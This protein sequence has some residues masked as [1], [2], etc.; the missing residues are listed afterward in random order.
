MLCWPWH[1]HPAQKPWVSHQLQALPQLLGLDAAPETVCSSAFWSQL[2][3][4]SCLL[5]CAISG[6]E[7]GV[8]GMSLGQLGMPCLPQSFCWFPLTSSVTTS[9]AVLP[10]APATVKDTGGW[11]PTRLLGAAFSS[12]AEDCLPGERVSWSQQ[13]QWCGPHN[14]QP[15]CSGC[16]QQLNF[17]KRAAS[18]AAP[19]PGNLERTQEYE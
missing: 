14:K 8:S 17:S 16:F 15:T 7:G 18:C 11:S 5:A 1:A 6:W 12:G 3:I 10:T 2:C 13:P 4:F 9:Q 19:L